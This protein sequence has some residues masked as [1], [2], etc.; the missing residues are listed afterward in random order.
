MKNLFY[1]QFDQERFPETTTPEAEYRTRFQI[2]RDRIIFSPPFRSLQS[3][4]QVFQSGKYDFYR[5]RLTHSI[6]VAKIARSIC[7]Y[8]RATSPLLSEDFYIDAD[9]AE[10]VGL[11]HDLGHPPFGHIGERKLNQVMAPYGGFEG[12]AQTLR[13]L[14][15][16]IYQRPGKTEGIAPTRA[17]I[18]GVMK[19]KALQSECILQDTN[20][21]SIYPENH[22][23][24]DEQINWRNIVF[25]DQDLSAPKK[26]LNQI[27]SIECQ[28]MD[29]A[30]D[31]AYSLHDIVDGISARY[32]SL[33][34]LHQ[35]A[36][37]QT[38]SNDAQ[39][40]IDKLSQVIVE[41]RVESYFGSR[42]GHFI[43][44]VSLHKSE[45]PLTKHTNRHSFLIK[46]D[47]AIQAE[48]KL[49]KKIATQLIF[50]SPQLQQIEFKGGQ[51]IEQLFQALSEHSIQH[52]STSL[53]LLPK[54]IH[55]L[56]E[57]EPNETGKYRR[58][59]DYVSS[60]TD[61]QAI[62]TY[63][64]LFDPDFGSIAELL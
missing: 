13:L 36:A 16:L 15:Q 47:P 40:L 19:Y 44:A 37:N 10:V 56:I 52:R 30:D 6:E 63:K 62:R 26:E 53:E 8:L 57:K 12:N 50:R 64:R 14:T 39:N 48:C 17:F 21:N 25:Y 35:W 24:Y 55:T 32:I 51:I 61:A 60:M 58:L 31:T 9:L 29:W 27:K 2:E 28:I 4:T 7:D 54:H 33:K 42:V 5:T 43:H 46:I 20:N 34:S 11:S 49:Y 23:I 18:D 3:K 1:N 38:L 59:C 45:N 41:D 22:F